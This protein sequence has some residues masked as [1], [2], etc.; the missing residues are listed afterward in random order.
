[1]RYAKPISFLIALASVINLTP[2]IGVLSSARI[3]SLYD[4]Q[5]VDPAKELLLRHR[6]VLFGIVGGV[7]LIGAF[8]KAYQNLAIAI[9]LVSMASF[10][11]LYYMVDGDIIGLQKIVAADIVGIVA[12]IIA[13]ILKRM[14]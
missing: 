10:L 3:E 6:A 2:L 4:I 14:D 7:M 12:L 9:G 1:M 5:I 13:I 8:R 11:G